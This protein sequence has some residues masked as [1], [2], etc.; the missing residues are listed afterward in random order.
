[1]IDGSYF[2]VGFEMGKVVV[3]TDAGGRIIGVTFDLKGQIDEFLS[4]SREAEEVAGYLRGEKTALDLEADLSNESGFRRRVYRRVMEI[5]YG[6]IS[7]Y[8][9]IASLA[10][11]PGGA[12]AVGQA[13]AANRFPLIIPCHR[14]LSRHGQIGGFSSGVDLKRHLLRLEG[15]DY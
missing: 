7:T 12:R 8:G 5:P 9:A 11:C 3:Y 6:T 4:D 10:G 2:T 15:L 14:V 1:V 13:M